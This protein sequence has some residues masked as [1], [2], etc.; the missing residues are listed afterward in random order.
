MIDCAQ[1]APVKCRRGSSGALR[2]C[3]APAAYSTRQT[4]AQLEAAAAAAW[5]LPGR[6]A[7]QVGR[8]INQPQTGGLFC[9][10][11]RADWPLAA[12]LLVARLRR[13]EAS[14]RL[15]SM[16]LEVRRGAPRRAASGCAARNCVTKAIGSVF[17]QCKQQN[18]RLQA[19]GDDEA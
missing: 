2:T 11:L 13:Q 18:N 15:S 19:A 9:G 16:S 7:R 8:D 5:G 6:R 3:R 10:H 1:L 17:S 12:R 14:S 4:S